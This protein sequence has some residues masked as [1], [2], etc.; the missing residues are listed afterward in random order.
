MGTKAK[1]MC[2]NVGEEFEVGKMRF[3]VEEGKCPDCFFRE[4]A[5]NGFYWCNAPI[6]STG[7][8]LAKLRKDGKQV[9]FKRIV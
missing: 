7:L 8:C 5:A 6:P 1:I 9:I 4:T 2:R 3:I